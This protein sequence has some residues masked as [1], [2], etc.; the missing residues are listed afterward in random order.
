ML[1]L[2]TVPDDVVL[3]LT[4]VPVALPLSVSTHVPQLVA[5]PEGGGGGG[6][7]C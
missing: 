4:V 3:S 6:G 2:L 7:R 1:Q 5:V